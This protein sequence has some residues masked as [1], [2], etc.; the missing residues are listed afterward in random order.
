MKRILLAV[1]AL[2]IMS[3]SGGGAAWYFYFREQPENPDADLM[4]AAPIRLF[5]D[6]DPLVL[7]V[8]RD[9]R[10]I[11]HIT[12]TIILEVPNEEAKETISLADLRLK[13]AFRAELFALYSKRYIQNREDAI[14]ILNRRLQTVSN[15]VLGE[16][17]IER[18]LVNITSKRNLS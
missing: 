6:F 2:L 7:P 4:A 18:V 15:R 8:I 16:G 1:L 9:G 3:G 10:V 12:F 13:D 17:V 5:V 11:Q 14:T